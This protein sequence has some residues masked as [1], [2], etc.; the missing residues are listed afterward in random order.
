MR[1]YSLFTINLNVLIAFIRIFIVDFSDQTF[2]KQDNAIREKVDEVPTTMGPIS[3][4]KPPLDFHSVVL[5]VTFLSIKAIT[6]ANPQNPKSVV[7]R[8]FK[9]SNK[10]NK[11]LPTN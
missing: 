9:M 2:S 5:E 11:N 1:I 4:Q 6:W 3:T 10:F 8:C 7:I